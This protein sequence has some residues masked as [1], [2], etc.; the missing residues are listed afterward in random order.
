MNDWV[1]AIQSKL[2]KMEETFERAQHDVARLTA[3]RDALHVPTDP[4][5]LSSDTTTDCAT[6]LS[7]ATTALNDMT[8]KQQ[9]QWDASRRELAVLDH[10]L[11]AMKE[12]HKEVF[13]AVDF[14]AVDGDASID[15][16][17]EM[18][19]AILSSEDALCLNAT[20]AMTCKNFVVTK[21]NIVDGDAFEFGASSE[22]SRDQLG[23]TLNATIRGVVSSG[24]T[25][26]LL[27]W[28]ENFENKVM[29]SLDIDMLSVKKIDVQ[30]IDAV[31][32]QQYNG[33]GLE[34]V[35]GYYNLP[36]AASHCAGNDAMHLLC[37][38]HSLFLRRAVYRD[39]F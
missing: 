18:G 10:S 6:A 28:D 23:P 24:A 35:K 33:R 31:R 20:A 34:R 32:V 15:G 39:K 38:M 22:I 36:A 2:N 11:D 17:T 4:A 21:K 8:K 13:I 5:V 29:R 30:R 19:I 27:F 9:K 7:G 3:E 14:E 16:L 12:G 37:I 25:P 1:S 26:V